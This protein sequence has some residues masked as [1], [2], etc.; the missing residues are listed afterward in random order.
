MDQD[1]VATLLLQDVGQ[2]LGEEAVQD[3]L[4]LLLR[5]VY[6][7]DVMP[8][9]IC[10]KTSHQSKHITICCMYGSHPRTLGVPVICHHSLHYCKKA[11][12]SGK[13]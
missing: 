12:A 11:M 8:R 3:P 10:S 2:G 5:V 13:Q 7:V 4:T 6:H 9:P 1:S